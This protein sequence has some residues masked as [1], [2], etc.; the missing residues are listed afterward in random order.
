MHHLH[1]TGSSNAIAWAL[2]SQT[3]WLPLLAIDLHDHWQAKVRQ[4]QE[5]AAAA[6][7]VRPA[8]ELASSG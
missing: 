3:I 8:S 1:R 5:I 7:R 2:L 6:A 4:E